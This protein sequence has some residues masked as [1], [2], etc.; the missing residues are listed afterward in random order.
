LSRFECKHRGTVP[1]KLEGQ[2]S[3]IF[4]F[5]AP[6]LNKVVFNAVGNVEAYTVKSIPTLGHADISIYVIE[7][8]SKIYYYLMSSVHQK[9]VP[10]FW[11]Y[12]PWVKLNPIG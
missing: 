5:I 6:T 12:S 1:K 10:R 4:L 3:V 9:E 11:I 2:N 7:F 8:I